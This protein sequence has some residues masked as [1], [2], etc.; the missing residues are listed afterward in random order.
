[1]TD[2]KYRA[3][4]A[5][6]AAFAKK[7]PP[8][9]RGPF[10]LGQIA[11]SQRDWKTAVEHLERATV[12]YPQGGFVW[13]N[14]AIARGWTGNAVGAVEALEKALKLE[15]NNALYHWNISGWY[16]TLFEVTQFREHQ[17]LARELN[18][19]YKD[20]KPDPPKK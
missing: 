4:V 3:A 13:N 2:D 20:R 1:M 6:A 9:F 10:L 7:Y 15:P 12:L 8:D 5:A 18:P 19:A 14:L 16:L 17:R 11:A